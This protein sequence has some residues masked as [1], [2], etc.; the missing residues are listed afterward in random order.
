MP[1]RDYKQIFEQFGRLRV[2]IVG[3]VMVDA[4]LFGKVERISP[5]AP[6]PVVLVEKRTNRLGGAANVAL[7]LKALGAEPILCSVIGNDMKGQEFMRLLE[8]EGIS[9]EALVTSPERITT[10]K[11][12]VIGNK[13]Q[14]LRV[15]EEVT[16]DLN[17][18]D[19]SALLEKINE[20]IESSSL[21]A[22]IFQDYNKGVLTASLIS[23]VIDK[24]RSHGIPVTV[25]PKRKNFFEYKGVDLF[26]PNLKELREGLGEDINIKDPGSLRN[27][28]LRLHHEQGINTLMITLSDEGVY[29]SRTGK[30]G[31]FSHHLLPAHVRNISDVSGAGDTVISVATLC[32]ACNLEP[33]EIAA[34]SNLAG[35][36]VC[37]EAGVV[38]VN[39]DKLL[40]EAISLL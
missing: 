33:V 40:K 4:Y 26:K 7:N 34:L 32:M 22:I 24:A 3:D 8:E 14:M 13:S 35:G 23:Q 19:Q 20:L 12:R 31:T 38:P 17:E 15:D 28:S 6:V 30:D 25:D 27:A 11:F 10:T 1:G 39:R 37:E 29:I 9:A 2:M 36:L 5:E 16:N 18:K 21:S